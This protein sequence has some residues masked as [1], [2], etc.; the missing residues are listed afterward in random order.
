MDVHCEGSDAIYR[1][2]QTKGIKVLKVHPVQKPGKLTA[3][4]AK[5]YIDWNTK[6]TGNCFSQND[7]IHESPLIQLFI[8]RSHFSENCVHV[9]VKRYILTGNH[10]SLVNKTLIQ[11]LC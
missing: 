5:I 1:R 3:L 9:Y 10:E 8:H 4:K 11:V 2:R 6:T 7:M